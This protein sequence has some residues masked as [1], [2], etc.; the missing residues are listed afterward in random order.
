MGWELA[1]WQDSRVP[2]LWVVFS[3]RIGLNRLTRD[4]TLP[5]SVVRSP[6]LTRLQAARRGQ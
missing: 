4:F 6:V 1:R 5:P 2:D 3:T